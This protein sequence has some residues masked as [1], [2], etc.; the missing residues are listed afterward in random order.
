MSNNQF[1]LVSVLMTAYNREQFITEA[2]ESVLASTYSNFELII[3]DDC[4]SDKTLEIARE[5]EKM[6]SRVKVYKNSN[7]LKDYPNRNKAAQYAQ[8]KYIKYLDSDDLIY[9]DG[10][11]YCIA[12]MEQFPSAGIGML[13][14]QKDY[15]NGSVVCWDSEKIIQHHFFVEGCLNIGPS[16]CIIRR[17]VFEKFLGFD[18]RF[19]V[20]SDNFFNIRLAAEYP[21][22]LMPKEFFF[23]RVHDGQEIKD[24]RGYLQNNYLYLKE[25]LNNVTLPLSE[26]Q[27]LQLHKRVDKSFSKDLIR[28]FIQSGSFGSIKEVMRV[29]RFGLKDIV[30]SL[31]TR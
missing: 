31:L 22:V 12:A 13:F 7:N 16:G 17:D 6:D 4:S 10:L 25:L 26:K 5:F 28:Y 23:Y 27:I 2:I 18:P 24:K 3:T 30:K 8:G 15:S 29:T 21:V 11:E 14:F 19:G 20:A 1:P 9:P